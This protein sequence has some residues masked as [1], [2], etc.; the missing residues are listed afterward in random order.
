VSVCGDCV[1]ALAF[2]GPVLP[3][4]Q[5]LALR[6]PL[7]WLGAA[8]GPARDLD[9]FAGE[10]LA[11]A[12]CARAGDAALAR[13]DD[14]VRTQRAAHYD[15]CA[16]RFARVLPR[17]CSKCGAGSRG[18]V[19]R[20]ALSLRRR[21]SSYRRVTTRRCVSSV[22]TARRASSR[23]IWPRRRRAATSSASS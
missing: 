5:Q 14:E 9:V 11:P 4:R 3:A 16:R 23:A 10:W 6:E 22:G 2:F 21:R 8:L 18:C 7:V 15:R 12:L 13:F 17:C 19:A 20:S 1:S